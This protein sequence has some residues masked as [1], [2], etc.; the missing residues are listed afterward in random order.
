ML[1]LAS[2]ENRL[3]LSAQKPIPPFTLDPSLTFYCPQEN[4]EAF[5]HPLVRS[6]H[7]HMRTEYEAPK[8][9]GGIVA[10]LLPCT[11]T[12]PYS[13]SKEHLEINTYLLRQG[14]EPSGGH[15]YPASLLES[16]PAAYPEEALHNG[17]L[18][19]GDTYL[20]RFV[21]SEP[22]GLVPYEHIYIWQG[23]LSPVARYDDPGLF[24]HRGTAIGLW[25]ADN[26]AVRLP[27]GKYRWGSVERA[28]YAEAHNRMSELMAATLSRLRW[29]YVTVVGYVSTKFTHRSFLTDR[30]EKAAIGLPAYKLTSEGR[31]PLVGVNDRMPGLVDVVPS[32]KELSAIHQTLGERLFQRADMTPGRVRAYFARGG[33]GATPL[34]LPEMLATLSHHLVA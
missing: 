7:T 28:A 33:G 24:E 12:K 16:L 21:V 19:R 27:N 6:F 5:E 8:A 32:A 25:R 17:L 26:S 9:D 1:D 3:A 23:Q 4:V 11:K 2:R 30:S 13:L 31:V 34:I 22:M 20:H 14:F 10:L 18:R 29:A 15:D